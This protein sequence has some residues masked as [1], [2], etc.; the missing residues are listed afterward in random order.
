MILELLN[1]KEEVLATYYSEGETKINFETI[2]PDKYVLRVIYD[3]NKNRKWDTG[4]YI[5]KIQPEE[6]IYFPKVLDVR[7]NW[8]VDEVFN[9]KP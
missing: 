2:L 8:D 4:N 7:A 3:D 1:E 6:V 5:E 9:L